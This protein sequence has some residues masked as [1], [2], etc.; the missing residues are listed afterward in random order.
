MSPKEARRLAVI[1]RA[2]RGEI[3]ARQA[4]ELLCL[5]TRQIKRLK[6]E[7]RNIGPAALAHKNRGRKPKHAVPDEIR[8][9]VIA[10][11][12]TEFRGASHRHM[13]E[14]LA[15]HKGISLSAKTVS[16]ILAAA[17]I[18]NP[19]S[20]KAPRCRRSRDRMP[21]AG[22]LVQAD[23]SCFPWFEDRGPLATLHAIIDDATGMILAAWFSP[24]EELVSYLICLKQLVENHGIPEAIFTDR[25]TIFFSPKL[26]KLSIEDELAGRTVN[27]TQFGLALA[28]LGIRHIPARSPQAKGRIE[29]LWQ[30]L[31]SRLTLELRLA[32]ISTIEEANAFL[33]DFIR[34]FNQQFAVQA[35]EPPAFRPAPSPAALADALALRETRTVSNG[36]TISFYGQAYQL[37]DGRNAVVPLRPRS[38]VTVLTRLDGSLW[39]VA[40]GHTYSLRPCAA[41]QPSAAQSR[42]QS[43]KPQQQPTRPVPAHN[44]PWRRKFIDYSLPRDPFDV[45]RALQKLRADAQSADS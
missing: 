16:R 42:E 32:G 28:Q 20:H 44:H 31:Q 9:Q 14:L 4:A 30:T 15:Q 40:D 34:R 33:V 22:L 17:G 10:L 41:P 25:H 36:S 7:Y 12:T 45:Y 6:G 8:Q 43:A 11:A 13:A 37:I 27:L 18:S 24:T 3:T 38:K 26:D 19:F 29:R 21:A 2:V 1:E 23:A 39:A 35:P 5:S